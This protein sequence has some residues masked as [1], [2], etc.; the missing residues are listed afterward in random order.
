MVLVTMARP[1]MRARALCKG[2]AVAMVEQQV[3]MGLSRHMLTSVHVPPSLTTRM[4]RG[5]VEVVL[6]VPFL[7]PFMV[8]GV[9]TS[10]FRESVSL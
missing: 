9:G 3:V 1:R 5:L 7:L 8:C 2:L 6:V 10:W 4:A